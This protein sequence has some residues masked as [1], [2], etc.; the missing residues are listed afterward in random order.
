MEGSLADLLSEFA[1][2]MLTD[3]PIQSILDRLV[4]RIVEVLPI[5]SAGVT[6][7]AEGSDPRYVS[8]S[9]ASALRFEKLQ[10]SLGEGPC[11]S[12]WQTGVAVS[13]P[14]L[15]RDGRF[16]VF[17]RAGLKAGLVAVFTF[18]LRSG[19]ARLGALDLYRSTPGP[20]EPPTMRAAQTLADV[21]AAY[22]LNAQARADLQQASDRSLHNAMHDPL[23]GLPNRA[24]F[25]SRLEHA[26]ERRRRS[27]GTMA[28]CFLDLDRFKDV[29]DTYG[30]AVGDELL[31][32]FA[33]RVGRELRSG[34]TLA[35]MAGDEFLVLL[36]EVKDSSEAQGIADRIS[37]AVSAPFQVGGVDVLTS[38]SIG[39]ACSDHPE[40]TAAQ[41]IRESD[42]A[43]YA[44]K[45]RQGG[46]RTSAARL[47]GV[48]DSN[49]GDLVDELEGAA[50]RGE[51]CLE[52]L[53]MAAVADGHPYG[54]EA[55]S[56][57][58]HPARGLI[59]SAVLL[60]AVDGSRVA[61]EVAAW[62]LDRACADWCSPTADPVSQSG[63]SMI[64]ALRFSAYQVLAPGFAGSV[65]R[66]LD[67]R[68]LGPEM[69]VIEL[70]EAALIQDED[71]ARVV[72]WEIQALGVQVG[73]QGFGSGNFSLN[74]LKRFPIDLVKVDRSLMVDVTRDRTAAAVVS[75]V[76]ALAHSLGMRALAEG[77]ESRTQLE[78]LK[79]EGCDL[80]QGPL[81]AGT[82]PEPPGWAA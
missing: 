14:D 68:Q 25:T 44:A 40:L 16:P 59:P 9:D 31:V 33:G 81:L 3:F 41:L 45:R 66:A 29:N 78:W 74:Y 52:Y 69:M 57:W 75:A 53:P 8:A 11:L 82:A 47:G 64:L 6:L 36:E 56:A 49:Q 1:S 12:A 76:V 30:H 38:A 4:G 21:A 58:S 80:F 26:I 32:A 54:C 2:T 20:L 48:L 77:I 24:L 71:R 67:A 7:I 61:S 60:N 22:L 5:T 55:L 50:A 23:T 10:T 70:P 17:A 65:H 27:G 46:R 72:L 43:M 73:L 62:T 28:V 34:D 51:L 79:E 35:R 15:T 18:P 13:V 42:T 39:I 19:D 37:A 63:R